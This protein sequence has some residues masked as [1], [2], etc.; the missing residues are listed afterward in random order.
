MNTNKSFSSPIDTMEA[1]LQAAFKPVKPSRE[2]V[3][4]VKNRINLSSP[5][6]AIRRASN[7]NS[8]LII[9]GSVLSALVLILT[10]TRALYY[11][12]GKSSSHA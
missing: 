7:P 10:V 12:L 9:L 5:A 2:F 1:Q 3:K 8:L 4:T 6:V 11:L